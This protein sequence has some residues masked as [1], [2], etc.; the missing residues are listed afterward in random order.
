MG[1]IKEVFKIA[2]TV[3]D[4]PKAPTNLKGNVF[5]Q[6]KDAIRRGADLGVS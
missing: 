2:D 6:I 3:I 4:L 5:T 1:K